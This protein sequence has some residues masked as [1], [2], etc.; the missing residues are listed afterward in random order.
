[1]KID[2]ISTRGIKR[3]FV[4]LYFI[5]KSGISLIEALSLYDRKYGALASNVVHIKKSLVYFV[6]AEAAV[7][8]KMLKP[9]AWED[10]KKY[11][12]NEVRKLTE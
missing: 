7:M 4:D 8:P 9:A 6:D 1:M 11:F 5:C 10:I 12:E 3:D 2:A